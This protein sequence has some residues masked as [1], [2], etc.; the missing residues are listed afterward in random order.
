MTQE[1]CLSVGQ[2]ARAGSLEAGSFTKYQPAQTGVFYR[3]AVLKSGAGCQ[4]SEPGAW[5]F[6]YFLS[7]I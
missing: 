2:D 1:R 3:G 5:F 4:A 6:N 7:V